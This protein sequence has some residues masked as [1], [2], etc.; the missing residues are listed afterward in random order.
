MKVMYKKIYEKLKSGNDVILLTLYKSVGSTPRKAGAKMAYF[1]N[2][3]TAGTIGGG[4][5]EFECT[6]LCKTAQKSDFPFAKEFTLTNAEAE[7]IGMVCGGKLSVFF[8]ILKADSITISLFEKVNLAFENNEKAWLK[9]S[10]LD[11]KID[12]FNTENPNTSPEHL[13]ISPTLSVDESH[14]I[15]PLSDGVIVYIFGG[16]HVS[17]SLCKMLSF[18][19]FSVV[20]YEDNEKF[21]DESLFPTAKKII[22]ADFMKINENIEITENDYCVVLTRGHKSDNEVLSQ[23]MCNH[24]SYLGVIGSKK[25]VVFMKDYLKSCGFSDSEID[26]IHSPI[27][28]S[29]GA[30]T[31]PEIAVSITAELINHRNRNK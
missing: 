31:P 21:C 22:S 26:K 13:P 1:Q 6:K 15:E 7:N 3:K 17:Q 4:T 18:T 23:I 14:F 20:I 27:G 24:P 16:G 12:F 8:Q 29:I 30:V 2:G 25:K 11:G 19:D 10:L 28:L 9:T 5:L